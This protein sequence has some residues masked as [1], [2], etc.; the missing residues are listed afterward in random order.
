[1]SPEYLPFT[2]ERNIYIITIINSLSFHIIF[3]PFA[4][5][6]FNNFTLIEV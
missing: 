5:L 1:M 2:T 6:Y 3:D 4:F